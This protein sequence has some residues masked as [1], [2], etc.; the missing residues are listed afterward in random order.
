MRN[1][2][3]RQTFAHLSSRW[4]AFHVYSDSR[5]PSVGQSNKR[6]YAGF[7]TFPVSLPCRINKNVEMC[8]INLQPLCTSFWQKFCGIDEMDQPFLTALFETWISKKNYFRQTT[9]ILLSFLGN[10]NMPLLISIQT[11]KQDLAAVLWLFTKS[12]SMFLAAATA[13]ITE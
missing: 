3:K 1:S 4:I 12:F 8:N 6:N 11:V 13:V 5:S 7:K 9:S 2:R 10:G